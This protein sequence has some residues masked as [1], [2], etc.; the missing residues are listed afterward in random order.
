M[1]GVYAGTVLFLWL[2]T[3]HEVSGEQQLD[4][5]CIDL[6]LLLFPTSGGS[7]QTATWRLPGAETAAAD[8]ILQISFFFLPAPVD[9]KRFLAEGHMCTAVR[10]DLAAIN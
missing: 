2:S 5:G 4:K 8:G 6:V 3:Q 1:V 9:R 7:L 10:N